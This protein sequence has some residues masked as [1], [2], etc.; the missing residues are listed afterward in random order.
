MICKIIASAFVV[1]SGIPAIAQ[2]TS[3]QLDG[4]IKGKPDGYIYLS[5]ENTATE[6]YIVD[7]AR[8]SGGKFAFKGELDG[9]VQAVVMMDKRGADGRYTYLYLVPAK[10]KLTLDYAS[11]NQSAVLKGSPIQDEADVL[12][13]SQADINAQLDPLRKKYDEENQKYIAAIKAKKDE[14]TLVKLK[15]EATKAKDAMDPYYEQLNKKQ[16]A[17]MDQHP[18]SFVTASLLRYSISSMPLAE[19]EK[20]YGLL[21]ADIQNSSLGK[22]IRK[23]LDGL[24]MGSPGATAYVFAS[25]ELRGQLLSLADYKGKYVL[26]DFWAS[27]CGPCRKGNPH[28]LGLYA[29]YRD[30]GLEIIGVSDDDGKPEAWA[31]AVEQDKI[32][33]WK[34]VL[35]GLDMDKRMKGEPNE[36]D[37]SNYYGI[38]SLPTKVLIDPNGVIIGRY[39]GGGENDEAMDKKLSEIFGG[40]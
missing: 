20:R 37:I 9:P 5:Y 22:A 17:F 27:W 32:G 30:K 7:S 2:Q 10:M 39:G 16:A 13:K 31:K 24:R 19:G 26:V 34:H 8:I 23:E 29:K 38:H 21:S 1:L 40:I 18:A 33:V 14:A 28:L 25:K 35:R 6:K 4:N 11:F 12:K 36:S 15:E 3:F